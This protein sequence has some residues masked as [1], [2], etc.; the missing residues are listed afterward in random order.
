ML[1]LH[2]APRVIL[3]QFVQN[4]VAD[5]YRGH[6]VKCIRDSSRVSRFSERHL[7]RTRPQ[8]VPK[9]AAFDFLAEGWTVDA[10]A[11]CIGLDMKPDNCRLLVFPISLSFAD[12]R[13]LS[14]ICSFCRVGDIL[15]VYPVRE[16]ADCTRSIILA[17]CKS[18]SL[19]RADFN[20]VQGN[21]TRFCFLRRF[22]QCA[23]EEHGVT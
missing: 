3:N 11:Q 6:V 17:E 7:S 2:P 21:D 14:D 19:T 13:G 22:F 12:G 20:I 5:R 10:M 1:G 18:M 15:C 4:S 8:A 9:K 23:V 16:E